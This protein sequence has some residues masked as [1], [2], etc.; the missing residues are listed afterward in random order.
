MWARC[1]VLLLSLLLLPAVFSNVADA[2]VHEDYADEDDDENERTPPESEPP[3]T[4]SKRALFSKGNCE[5]CLAAGGG[6]CVGAQN[7]VEDS[8]GGCSSPNDHIGNP[9]AVDPLASN[10]W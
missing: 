1:T 8:R 3:E 4:G 6:W 7:C 9:L 10:S 2:E 5:A